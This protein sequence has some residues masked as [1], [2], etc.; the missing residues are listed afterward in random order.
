VALGFWGFRGVFFVLL[1]S[2]GVTPRFAAQPELNLLKASPPGLRT[3][4]YHCSSSNTAFTFPL[5]TARS[6]AAW[7]F[8]F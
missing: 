5:R 2:S 8:S 3:R 1:A 4:S 7:S 6:K